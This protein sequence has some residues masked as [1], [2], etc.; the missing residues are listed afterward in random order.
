MRVLILNQAFYPDVVSTAQHASDLAA[1][2]AD[3][4]HEVWAI[5]SNRGY[6]NPQLRFAAREQWH[7]VKIVRVGSSG[8]GKQARWRRTLDF[9]TFM[10]RCAFAMATLP[11]VD[12]VVALTSPPLISF[13]AALS[14]PLKARSFVIWSMDV[15]PDEALAAGWLRRNSLAARFLDAIS[16]YTLRRADR[17]VVLDRLMR[18]RIKAKGVSEQRISVIPP[19]SHDDHV[20]FDAAERD[21][22]RREHGLTN[23]FVVMYSGNH[24]PCHPLDTLLGAARNLQN[25]EDI[26]F[27][28]VGG[29]S[30]HRRLQRIAEDER[31]A[32]VRFLPYQPM[33]RLS[34]SLSS[35]DLH[36][37]VMGNEFPGIVHPCK[38]YNILSLGVP[39][40]YVGPADTHISDLMEEEPRCGA[41]F[42]H[43]DATGVAARIAAAADAGL[44]P[45]AA[46]NLSPSVLAARFSKLVLLPA[47]IAAVEGGLLPSEQKALSAVQP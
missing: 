12:V 28:L 44:L 3:A 17:V 31:L 32:N 35:A 14:V 7:G 19:W 20:K 27:C 6:D 8:F 33:N 4:G 42:D 43:S 9:A 1:G 13:L 39:F 41:R 36:V 5:A 25:R 45:S 29:G 24:S 23:K 16:R 21:G 2:L 30:E 22:F 15:N 11:R 10:L 18:D 46:L 26:V 34:A 38:V 37:V 47:M 40:L